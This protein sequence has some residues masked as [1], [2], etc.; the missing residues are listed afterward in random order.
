MP[1]E[2]L[3]GTYVCW[4]MLLGGKIRQVYSFKGKSRLPGTQQG[5]LSSRTQG[6]G[7]GEMRSGE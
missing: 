3:L 1:S 4:H 5:L 2:M 7:K 6:R